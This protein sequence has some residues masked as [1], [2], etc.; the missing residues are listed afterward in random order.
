[1]D[2]ASGSTI[3]I[4]I[5]AGIASAAL[6]S[7]GLT[8]QRKSHMLEDAKPSTEPARPPWK[9]KRWLLGMAI[10]LAA[11]IFGSGF[12][13]TALPLV[14]LAPLQAS[15][16]V[17]NSICATV[18]L[19]EPFTRYSLVGTVLVTAGAILIAAFGAIAEPNHSLEELLY[20]LA[21]RDFLIWFSATIAIGV[22]LLIL[23]RMM[24]TWRRG[25]THR[26]KMARGIMFGVISGILS[27][28]TLL[29]AK[30]AV[31]LLVRSIVDKDNQFNRY[32]SWLIVIGIGVIA[33][34]QLYFLHQGLKLCS[35]SVLYPLIF[36]VYNIIAI[37]DGLIYYQQGSRLSA[38]Q[39]GLVFLGTILLLLGVAGL[40]WRL[41]PEA[42]ADGALAEALANAVEDADEGDSLLSHV[43]VEGRKAD[44]TDAVSSNPLTLASTRSSDD[45]SASSTSTGAKLPWTSRRLDSK[46]QT[47]ILTELGDYDEEVAY[48][49]DDNDSE[50]FAGDESDANTAVEA[51]EGNPLLPARLGRLFRRLRN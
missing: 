10:F 11:N 2:G 1:M 22:F 44:E 26:G 14:I 5:V 33:L 38:T 42:T 37:L 50:Y 7:V 12:Q 16:L 35:T 28:H 46:E 43:V 24:R 32:E 23:L 45:G 25:H 20:L 19:K 51:E 21:Q 49:Y 9:R 17:F 47:E 40:S 6:Q 31:E 34:T 27:A 29:L 41:S 39:V 36:C 3:A 30:S 13:I 8:Q 4:G 18:F 15:G 48:T